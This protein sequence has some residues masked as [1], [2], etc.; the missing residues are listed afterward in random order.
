MTSRTL[1]SLLAHLWLTGEVL[2]AALKCP[3][4]FYVCSHLSIPTCP[5]TSSIRPFIPPPP[6]LY[7]RAEDC[8][9]VTPWKRRRRR[10]KGE[11]WS[12]SRGSMDYRC[13]V[14]RSPHPPTIC[15]QPTTHTITHRVDR[16]KHTQ[17]KL[18]WQFYSRTLEQFTALVEKQYEDQSLLKT[19]QTLGR[20]CVCGGSCILSC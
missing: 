14:S 20:T 2:S 4:V 6:T 19:K 17:I 13:Q 10:E 16:N 3:G 11:K 9:Q 15:H 8:L 7:L 1:A 18:W 5:S 12:I